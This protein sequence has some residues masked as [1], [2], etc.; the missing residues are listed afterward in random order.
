METKYN[1]GEKVYFE[2]TIKSIEVLPSKRIMY[3]VKEWPEFLF[4]E[5]VLFQN[6]QPLQHIANTLERIEKKLPEKNDVR[7]PALIGDEKI[8]EFTL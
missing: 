6:G 1:V 2:A 3:R 7:I 4:S 5:D 8:D